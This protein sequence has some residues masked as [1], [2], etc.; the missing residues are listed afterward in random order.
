MN[1]IEEEIMTIQHTITYYKKQ[2]Q[3]TQEKIQQLEKELLIR[4]EETDQ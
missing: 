3:K 1:K 4:L 2:Q